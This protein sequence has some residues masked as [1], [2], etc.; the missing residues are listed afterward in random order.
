M[1]VYT[2]YNSTNSTAEEVLQQSRTGMFQGPRAAMVGDG[3]EKLQ[4]TLTDSRGQT[5][6]EE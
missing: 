5:K 2:N 1:L 3:Y 6:E 4:L